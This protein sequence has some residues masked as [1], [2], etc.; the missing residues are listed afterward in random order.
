MEILIITIITR[1]LIAG[2][3]L[4]LGTVGEI[5]TERAGILNLGAEGCMA[6]GAV[7]AFVVGMLSKFKSDSC[8]RYRVRILSI[9][10][11]DLQNDKAET[12]AETEISSASFCD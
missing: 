9:A 3:P 11:F 1:T 7:A 8:C 2:V 6:G 12:S 5:I 4:L 10:A